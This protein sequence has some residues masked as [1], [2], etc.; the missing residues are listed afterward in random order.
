M[1]DNEKTI[2]RSELERILEKF[3][4]QQLT[5]ELPDSRLADVDLNVVALPVEEG[6]RSEFMSSGYLACAEDGCGTAKEINTIILRSLSNN[7]D[8]LVASLRA[9]E[10]PM[11]KSL[12]RIEVSAFESLEYE[13]VMKSQYEQIK[14]EK[15]NV[16]AGILDQV[17][18]PILVSVCLA[19]SAVVLILSNL[20]E[21][22]TGRD[23]VTEGQDVSNTVRRKINNVVKGVEIR[24]AHLNGRHDRYDADPSFDSESSEESVEVSIPTV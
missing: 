2:D 17:S 9:S 14:E 5:L 20:K 6:V 15:E 19:L 21:R 24:L 23:E 16:A 8:E 22:G 11:L 7:T 13:V 12:A 3:I 1:R 4:Y 18:V 10:D